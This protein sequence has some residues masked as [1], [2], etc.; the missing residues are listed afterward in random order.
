MVSVIIQDPYCALQVSKELFTFLSLTLFV[1]NKYMH[2]IIF[3]PNSQ[4]TL[5]LTIW[6]AVELVVTQ[7]VFF[8]LVPPFMMPPMFP[9]W[10]PMNVPPMPPPPSAEAPAAPGLCFHKN[11]KAAYCGVDLSVME[12]TTKTGMTAQ[13]YN[14]PPPPQKTHTVHTHTTTNY[15]YYK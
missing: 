15:Y 4:L 11:F 10:P 12:L 9:G 13:I 1:Q 14:S 2:I 8:L 7:F 3:T 6:S 5:I